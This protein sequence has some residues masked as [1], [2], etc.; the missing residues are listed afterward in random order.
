M[1]HGGIEVSDDELNLVCA[2]SGVGNTRHCNRLPDVVARE[3]VI[4]RAVGNARAEA[5]VV[6]CGGNVLAAVE[7]AVGVRSVRDAGKDSAQAAAA[8]LRRSLTLRS[9]AISAPASLRAAAAL[10]TSSSLPSGVLLHRLKAVIIRLCNSYR[11]ANAERER[12]G[13]NCVI[14]EFLPETLFPHQGLLEAA[15]KALVLLIACL[16]CAAAQFLCVL[17]HD[18][19]LHDIPH[20]RVVLKGL[21]VSKEGYQLLFLND[22]DAELPDNLPQRFLKLHALPLCVLMPGRRGPG[23]M[24]RTFRKE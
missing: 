10:R 21:I 3:N 11:C 23:L 6:K 4:E 5:A 12:D 20:R 7:A 1:V 17:A 14:S 2:G 9:A 13:V 8:P 22:A 16:N 24:L 15:G 19:G 18:D